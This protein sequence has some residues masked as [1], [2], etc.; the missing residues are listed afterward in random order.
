MSG[1]RSK[2]D[3]EPHRYTYKLMNEI[4]VEHFKIELIENYPCDSKEELLA[5]EGYYIR[6]MKPSLN[7][8]VAGRSKNKLINNIVQIIKKRL[9][10]I[11]NI[12]KYI[13]KKQLN[14]ININIGQGI[15]IK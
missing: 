6:T 9:K 7:R 10:S 12:I 13:T 3:R 4:G 2:I 15:Q 8:N 14:H 1:H 11:K 5:K